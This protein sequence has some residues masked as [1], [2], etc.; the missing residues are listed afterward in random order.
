[1]VITSR[2]PSLGPGF[3][4]KGGAAGGGLSQ[5]EPSSKIVVISGNIMLMPGLPKISRAASI[6]VDASGKIIGI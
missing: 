1:V 3:E 5:I 2:E 4:M 6:D